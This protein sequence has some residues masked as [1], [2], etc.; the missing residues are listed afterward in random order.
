MKPKTLIL[1]VV[2]VGCGLVASYMTSRV[3]AE[4]G[5]KDGEDEK[6]TVLVARQNIPMGT[7]IKEPEKLFEEKQ[8]T[9]GEEPRKAVRSFDQVKDHRLSK[10]LS[11]EQFVTPEDLTTRDQEGLPGMMQ[12][13]MR[14]VGLKVNIDTIVAGFVL[15]H[16]RVD[17]IH[18]V[19]RNENESYAKTLLQ[20][21]LVLAVDTMNQRP[22]DKQA[23][24]SSTVTVQ[25][26]PAQAEK[27]SLATELGTLRLT[28]RSWGDDEKVSGP[29]ATPK[30]IAEG[31]D[32]QSDDGLGQK[33]ELVIGSRTPSWGLKVPDVPASPVM[34]AKAPEPPPPPRTHTM[35]VYNG[36][37]VTRA[38]YTLSDKEGEANVQIQK[39]Q[40]EPAP[41]PAVPPIALAPAPVTPLAPALAPKKQ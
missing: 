25:V 23:V 3:I 38:V 37:A 19:R 32:G 8:F 13:G 26:T 6:V 18:I 41:T 4:R 10:P 16:S 21:I 12:K 17:I 39:T 1:L 29:G 5:A 14:A 11:A 7:L 24:V 33:D 20:N 34:E 40:P 36:E 15:P 9:K 30:T 31:G 28:L 22:E 27:L 35:T 2:A